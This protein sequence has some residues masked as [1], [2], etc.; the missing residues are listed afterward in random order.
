MD[1][2][3]SALLLAA[4]VL[5]VDLTFGEGNHLAAQLSGLFS[6]GATLTWPT[7]VQED[8]H[9]GLVA[10]RARRETQTNPLAPAAADVVS[11]RPAATFEEIDEA[12]AVERIRAEGVHLGRGS[13]ATERH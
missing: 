7:G 2:L 11:N 12:V 3:V 1:V 6:S 8:D 4:F 9:P 5:F 10:Q 13:R